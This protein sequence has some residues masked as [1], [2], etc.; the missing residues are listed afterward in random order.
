[1]CAVRYVDQLCRDAH[2]IAVL[3]HGAFQEIAHA[4]LATDLLCID[5]PTLVGKCRVAGDDEEPPDAGKRG[6]YLLDH[7][8]G[9]ILLLRIATQIGEGKRRDRRLIGK[10]ERRWCWR[11]VADSRGIANS[12]NPH[13]PGNVLQALLTDVVKVAIDLA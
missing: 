1:M 13:W 4:E 6:D 10:R 2:A 5:C 11:A 7:T 3:S 9:E 8:V 12:I